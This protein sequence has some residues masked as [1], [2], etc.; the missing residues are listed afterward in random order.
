MFF[1]EGIQMSS[2]NHDRILVPQAIFIDRLNRM[3]A[4]VL[5]LMENG[6]LRRYLNPL[7]SFKFNQ[8]LK[9]SLQIAEGNSMLG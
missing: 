8:L 1:R 7:Q 9:F 3:P 6:D 2:F 4:I 5:P